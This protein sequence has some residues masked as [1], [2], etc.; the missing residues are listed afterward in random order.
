[1]HDTTPN[2]VRFLTGDIAERIQARRDRVALQALQDEARALFDAG[3]ITLA[4]GGNRAAIARLGRA[5][6]QAR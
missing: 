3:L 2:A 4:T 6:R 1:M 5:Y